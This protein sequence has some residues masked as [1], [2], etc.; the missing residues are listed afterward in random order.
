MAGRRRIGRIAG[1]GGEGV[2]AYLVT[3]VMGAVVLLFLVG[4]KKISP[5]RA[6]KWNWF[7]FC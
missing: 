2:L 7:G 5:R 1:I 6:E 4:L 3:A